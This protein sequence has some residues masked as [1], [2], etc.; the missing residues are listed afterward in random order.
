MLPY[1]DGCFFRVVH[2]TWAGV[3]SVKAGSMVAE[4]RIV[5]PYLL[6]G[7]CAV[8]DALAVGAYFGAFLGSAGCPLLV[9]P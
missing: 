8:A 7:E 3:A 6:V 4:H 9:V 2:A 1:F 5:L